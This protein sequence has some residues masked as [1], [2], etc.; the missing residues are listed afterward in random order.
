[1]TKKELE[2]YLPS[3]S[4]VKVVKLGGK[5]VAFD[6]N[7][8]ME[9]LREVTDSRFLIEVQIFDFKRENDRIAVEDAVHEVRRLNRLES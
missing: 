3:V 5:Y 4:P 9:A 1:V 2:K 7:G 8:R 6:G